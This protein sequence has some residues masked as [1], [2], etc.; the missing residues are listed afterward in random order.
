M[1]QKKIDFGLTDNKN[2]YVQTLNRVRKW[3]RLKKSRS[4]CLS[5]MLDQMELSMA[6]GGQHK[7]S[8]NGRIPQ[9]RKLRDDKFI[10]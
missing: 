3:Y 7:P 6:S 9:R 8:I 4:Y 10:I 5:S 2:I 1:E